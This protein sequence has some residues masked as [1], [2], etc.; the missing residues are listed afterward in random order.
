MSVRQTREVAEQPDGTL[1]P[2]PCPRP[3]RL[4]QPA[5]GVRPV[6]H[7]VRRAATSVFR[8]FQNGRQSDALFHSVVQYIKCSTVLKLS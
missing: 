1:H 6:H 3:V 2:R 7:W 8:C 4:L 5:M